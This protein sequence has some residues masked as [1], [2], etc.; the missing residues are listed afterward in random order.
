MQSSGP[1]DVLVCNVGTAVPGEASRALLAPALPGC[2]AYA[3]VWAWAPRGSKGLRAEVLRRVPS[4]PAPAR[5]QEVPYK[6]AWERQLPGSPS[7]QVP[8]WPSGRPAPPPALA[9]AL[10]LAVPSARHTSL[11]SITTPPARR[12][13]SALSRRGTPHAPPPAAPTKPVPGPVPHPSRSTKP[14]PCRC[15]GTCS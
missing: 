8:K 7:G 15:T 10:A 12:E 6:A 5:G 11:A 2:P 9:L 4:C 14:A 13:A 3:E 1:I